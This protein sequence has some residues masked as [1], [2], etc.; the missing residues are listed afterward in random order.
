MRPMIMLSVVMATA[1]KK[2]FPPIVIVL[3]VVGILV[4]L[5]GGYSLMNKG[6]MMKGSMMGGPNAVTSIKDALTKSVSMEC[7][8]EEGTTKTKAWI[9][10]GAIRADVVSEDEQSNGSFIMKDKDKKMYFW[11]EKEGYVMTI[12]DSEEV[13]GSESTESSPTNDIMKDLEEY[14]DHCKPAV[15]SDS[16]FNPPSDVTFQDM[17]EMMNGSGSGMSEEEV[18]KMME[19]Y[20]SEDTSPEDYMQPDDSGY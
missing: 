4:V 11:N 17:S 14:K 7:E 2:G 18:K 9:K 13:E 6:G 12:P 8:Y 20:Q 1:K 5:G 16:L 15:V 10:N 19:Q 3:L